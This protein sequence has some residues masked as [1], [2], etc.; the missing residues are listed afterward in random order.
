MVRFTIRG[1]GT[2]KNVVLKEASGVA[3]IDGCI[4][5]ALGKAAFPTSAGETK[6]SVPL[7]W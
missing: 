5:D 4:K 3:K 1:D 7:A 6:V 2:V